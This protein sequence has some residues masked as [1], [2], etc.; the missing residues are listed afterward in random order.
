LIPENWKSI[1]HVIS[2]LKRRLAQGGVFLL[3][4]LL[5]KAF[6]RPLVGIVFYLQAFYY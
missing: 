3:S 1:T 4:Y 6:C 5:K 2:N